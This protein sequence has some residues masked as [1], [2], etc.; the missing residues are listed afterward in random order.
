MSKKTYVH[1][2]RQLVETELLRAPQVRN[3]KTFEVDKESNKKEIIGHVP[4]HQLEFRG[5]NNFY[6]CDAAKF[7]CTHCKESLQ[8]I[9][10]LYIFATID[11]TKFLEI[12]IGDFKDQYEKLMN[13]LANT[14]KKRCYI[15]SDRD[16]V[17]LMY[18]FVINYESIK[19]EELNEPERKRLANINASRIEKVH[20][21][22]PAPI[23]KEYLNETNM[24]Y[25]RHP[26]NLYAKIY[27]ILKKM[28]IKNIKS[29]IAGIDYSLDINYEKLLSSLSFVEGYL[30]F[31]DYLY[32]HGAGDPKKSS[33]SVSEMDL[34]KTCMPSL[35]RI[36]GAGHSRPR[37]VFEYD[38]FFK[39]VVIL[40]NDI[41]GFDYKIIGFPKPDYKR[42]RGWKVFNLEH[43]QWPYKKRGLEC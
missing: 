25:Y 8:L 36:D 13:E 21:Q 20:F 29:L 30:K 18:P 22:F 27:D 31:F 10:D 34:M 39:M 7:V 9:G 19:I 16:T 33:L 15:S 1:N 40:S 2:P 43:P 6:L 24:Q 17:F 41:E 28:D 14:G 12:T 23:F 35:I 42:G 37:N 5:A 3:C 4:R 32:K 38:A 11:Y 26:V